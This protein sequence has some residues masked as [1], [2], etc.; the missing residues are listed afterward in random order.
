M[1]WHHVRS[2]C[3]VMTHL[4]SQ[5]D[6]M[7]GK[8]IGKTMTHDN[9][10]HKLGL[11]HSKRVWAGWEG[12]FWTPLEREYHNNLGWLTNYP[13]SLFIYRLSDEGCLQPS[14][15]SCEAGRYQVPGYL[16][17]WIPGFVRTCTENPVN[18]FWWDFQDCLLS[19]SSCACLIMIKIRGPL[20]SF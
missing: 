20:H 17:S 11:L 14:V 10:K 13:Y 6:V 15:R 5:Y 9:I 1:V 8:K 16:G 7:W 4:T 18:R 3:D 12:N 19:W 2:Q